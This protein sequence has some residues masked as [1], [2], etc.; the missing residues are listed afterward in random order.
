MDK[1]V[2]MISLVRGISA[3]D[4]TSLS[5]SPTNSAA[6]VEEMFTRMKD[7]SITR[8]GSTCVL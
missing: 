7:F 5:I 3:S 4:P 2:T 8:R 6:A 1:P